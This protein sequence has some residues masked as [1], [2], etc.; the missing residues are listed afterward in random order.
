MIC[1]NIR[2]NLPKNLEFHKDERGEIYDIFFNEKIEHVAIIDSKPNTQRGNH[3]HKQTTQHMLIT[4]GSLEYWYKEKDSSEVKMKLLKEG[5]LI[6][7]PPYEIHALKILDQGN[8]F[9]VFSEGIRGGKN[10]EEDTY[11]VESIFPK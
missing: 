11:R 9:L 7:T 5:D 1:R 2:K 3:Y 10:Y 4:K 6:T 8:E